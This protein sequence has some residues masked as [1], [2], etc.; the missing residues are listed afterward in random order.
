MTTEKDIIGDTLR[1]FYAV[2]GMPDEGPSEEFDVT[3]LI[4]AGHVPE[5]ELQLLDSALDNQ[6]LRTD[7]TKCH[8]ILESLAIRLTTEELLQELSELSPIQDCEFDQLH[9]GVQWFSLAASLDQRH[10][11]LPVTPFDND[12]ELSLPE[13]IQMAVAGS[14]VFRLYIALC[15]MREGVLYNMISQGA[16]DCKPCC[17]QVKKLLNSD[18]I[19]HLRNALSHSSFSSCI[20]GLVFRDEDYTIVATSG[21]LEWLCTWLMLIQLQSLAAVANDVDK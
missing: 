10:N 1:N 9:N 18:Y 21:F 2:F 7:F 4:S 19:R 14:L 20:V 13:K 5:R 16:H 3:A 15:Y 8:G 12:V 17:S 11:G 6:E